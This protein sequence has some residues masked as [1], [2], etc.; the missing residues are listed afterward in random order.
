MLCPQQGPCL[1]GLGTETG[2]RHGKPR[3][4]VL[5]PHCPRDKPA[6]GDRLSVGHVRE[7]RPWVLLRSETSPRDGLGWG[8]R[9]HWA[10]GWE[11]TSLHTQFH[12]RSRTQPGHCPQP[13]SSQQSPA[14]PDPGTAS[15]QVPS[16]HH[17]IPWSHPEH[18]HSL[19]H[20]PHERPNPPVSYRCT[21]L[22]VNSKEV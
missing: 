2:R 21:R 1:G 13:S 6:P 10:A 17:Q 5:S 7:G 19:P 22:S 14:K 16:L 9:W 20:P 3:A 4:P 12:T 15:P 8:H 11:H 18:R